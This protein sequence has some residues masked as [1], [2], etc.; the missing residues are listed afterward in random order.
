MYSK[1]VWWTD[2]WKTKNFVFRNEINSFSK[3]QSYPNPQTF[4]HAAWL[5]DFF[6]HFANVIILYFV[7]FFSN[8][9]ARLKSHWNDFIRFFFCSI[10]WCALNWDM[11][12][13]FIWSFFF[14]YFVS[15]NT[16]IESFWF[17][18]S[19]D[20]FYYFDMTSHY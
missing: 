19:F 6:W 16:S 17:H 2:V 4:P 11:C 18:I 12:M 7:F 5:H 13:V 3:I 10:A 1:S 15:T 8:A 9:C 14:V 20:F